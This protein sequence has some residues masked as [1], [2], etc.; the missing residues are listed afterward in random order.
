MYGLSTKKFLSESSYEMADEPVLA[1]LFTTGNG[2]MGVRG[3]FEEFGSL[4]IQGAFVRGFIDEIIEVCEPFAD[5][6]YM[7]KYYLNEEGLKRFERQESGIN[8][9]DFLL[10]RVEI[11]GKTFFP[12]EGRI[13]EWERYLDPTAAEYVRRVVWDDGEGNLTRLEFRRFASFAC[14]N[15]YCQRVTVHPLNHALPVR[16]LSGVDT[17]VKTGGQFVTQTD[18]ISIRGD[19]LFLSFHTTAKYRFRA[20]YAICHTFPAGKREE[21]S[22]NGRYAVAVCCEP[23]AEYVLEKAVFVGTSRDTQQDVAEWVKR[24]GDALDRGYAGQFNAHLAAYSAYF[25]PMDVTVSGDDEAD[26]YL[27]LASYHTAIS[28]PRMDWVH[29]VAAKGLTGERYNQF[30]WWDC[31]IHQLP[32]FLHTAPKTAKNL[33]LYRYR[34]LD[35]ARENAAKLGLDGAKF[36]FCSSVTGEER[37]WEYVR[38]PFLQVHVNSDIPYGVL[39]YYDCTGDE[40]FMHEYGF[41]IVLECLRYWLSR[42]TER[43]GRYEILQV[44]G[45][46]EHH[47]YV[48]NDAYTNYCVKRVAERFLEVSGQLGYPVQEAERSRIQDLAARMYLPRE[49]NG[50]IPQFD[51]YFSLSRGLEEVGKGT[52]KQFQMKKSGLYHKSQVIKQPDVVL[53]YTMVEAGADRAHF[54]ENWDYYEQM[55]ETSSSLTFP[56]HAIAS[57]QNGRM[58]SFDKYFKQTLKVD[59]EDLH[60]VAW[61][62]VHSGCLA[63]GYLAVLYGLFGFSVRPGELVFRPAPCPYPAVTAHLVHC[64]RKLRLTLGGGTLA[65]SLLEGEPI[66]VHVETRSGRES[67]LLAG[68]ERFCLE[69]RA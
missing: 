15:V 63:G 3:S 20:A 39:N 56:V 2:Y 57:A 16:L 13:V 67:R 31:E 52:L 18:A 26:G 41:E 28:A 42:V 4:R 50:M 40:K 12:W 37:V 27:R 33:L 32:F 7:K 59:A 5:N 23:S 11:G 43:S 19:D 69:V 30:V 65:L 29:G 22:E 38:H 54:A 53:L 25:A 36:A 44:T 48:D 68:E 8:M 45:T 55:C 62:G 61:Q 17:A 66:P 58:A 60:G 10:I 64:G 1:A 21:Y 51:G 49:E 47:P 46:D 9:P 14:Q 24:E 6:E 34:C 35:Q